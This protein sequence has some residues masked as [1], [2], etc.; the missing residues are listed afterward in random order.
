MQ[1]LNSYEYAVYSKTLSDSTTIVYQDQYGYTERHT[2][3]MN[4]KM[5]HEHMPDINVTTAIRYQQRTET[6]VKLSILFNAT[7][8][9]QASDV[10]SVIRHRSQQ[11]AT[12]SQNMA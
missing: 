1:T 4:N 12:Q 6:E 10:S 7:M 2:S 9:A 3:D 5:Y 11:H 8:Q